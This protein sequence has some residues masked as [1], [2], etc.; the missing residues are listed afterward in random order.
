MIKTVR[1]HERG[2]QR[3]D[4][5]RDV[6]SLTLSPDGRTVA[7]GGR[8]GTVKLWSAAALSQE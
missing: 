3:G 5:R 2:R 6:F 7:S 4:S 8:D 1:G